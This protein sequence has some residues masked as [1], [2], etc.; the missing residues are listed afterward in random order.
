MTLLSR[1]GCVLLQLANQKW[2]ASDLLWSQVLGSCKNSCKKSKDLTE[3]PARAWS[4]LHAAIGDWVAFCVLANLCRWYT[5]MLC[6][7]SLEKGLER[8]VTQR[9]KT[10]KLE[11]KLGF[12]LCRMDPES[13]VMYS[14]QQYE[15][16]QTDLELVLIVSC[17]MTTW[18]H[19]FLFHLRSPSTKLNMFIILLL[20]GICVSEGSPNASSIWGSCKFCFRVDFPRNK[21][22][23]SQ[24]KLLLMVCLLPPVSLACF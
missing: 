11:Q 10:G 6:Q 1:C 2:S 13:W 19:R 4:G 14:Q 16:T 23:C 15:K 20:K 21:S 18:Y 7:M 24:N 22:A 12:F 17:R 3:R 5:S 8:E 9:G